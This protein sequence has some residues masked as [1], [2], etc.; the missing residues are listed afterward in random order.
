VPGV[1]TA[2]LGRRKVTQKA[3]RLPAIAA[4][5]EKVKKA[6]LL[7]FLYVV[8][9]FNI[10][11]HLCRCC[12]YFQGESPLLKKASKD[13][14]MM[15]YGEERQVTQLYVKLQHLATWQAVSRSF[16]KA[17]HTYA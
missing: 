6:F 8:I 12:R 17:K 16:G 5:F 4:A 7:K 14:P 9:R 10:V 15:V 13:I 2:G 3:R 1:K 11:P